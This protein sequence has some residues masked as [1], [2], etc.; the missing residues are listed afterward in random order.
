MSIVREALQEIENQTVASKADGSAVR[1]WADAREIS[2][3][4]IQQCIGEHTDEPQLLLV[5]PAALMT[6][7]FRWGYETAVKRE[8]EHIL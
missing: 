2:F 8:R 6:F 4:E 7:G 1:E 3:D 5:S